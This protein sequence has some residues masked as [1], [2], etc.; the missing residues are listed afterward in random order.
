MKDQFAWKLVK[1][2][3]V[4]SI[5]MGLDFWEVVEAAKDY[6]SDVIKNEKI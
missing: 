4:M 6:C 1:E 2:I 3:E 5:E